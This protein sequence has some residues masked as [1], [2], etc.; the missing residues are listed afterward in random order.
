[1]SKLFTKDGWS[2]EFPVDPNGFT[3]A[4]LDTYL[5]GFQLLDKRS[6]HAS[7]NAS[8]H[9][10]PLKVGITKDAEAEPECTTE[11]CTVTIPHLRHDRAYI[12]YTCV[13]DGGFPGVAGM[14]LDLEQLALLA[15]W[16]DH[17]RKDHGLDA[18]LSR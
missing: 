6:G 10:Q 14:L 15:D 11:A 12:F 1:M 8:V 17:L 9:V 3:K 13:D 7:L 16:I 4:F 5:C 18:H 2:H